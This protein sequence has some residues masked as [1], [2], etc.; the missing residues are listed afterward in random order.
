MT[1]AMMKRVPAMKKGGSVSTTKRIAKY[2]E[3]HTIQTAKYAAMTWDRKLVTLEGRF[4][5]ANHISVDVRVMQF[6]RKV[7]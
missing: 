1:P 4:L 2:V 7:S 3:P 5:V 6:L